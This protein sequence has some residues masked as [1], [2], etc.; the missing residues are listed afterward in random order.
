VYNQTISYLEK[1]K[2]LSNQQFGFR[3][4]HSTEL[5][6]TLFLDNIR[7]EM[8]SGKLCGAVFVDLCKAFDTISHS[9]IVCKL[10]EYGII[11]AEKEW[12]TNY[13]FGRTQCVVFD[14][15]TSHVNPVF[16]GVPQGSI[17]G[18]LLFLIHFN[19]VCLPVKNCKILMYADDTVLYYAHKDVKIIEQKLTEDMSRLSEWFENNELIVSLKKGKT[20]CMLFG[21][22]RNLSKNKEHE[23]NIM[24][25]NT[26][27]N[28]TTSYT[29]LGV[30][31]DQTLNLAD[32]FNKIYKRSHGRL[33]L[34]L[35]IRKS[36]TMR[37]AA[38]VYNAMILPITM[39]CSLVNP[40]STMTRQQQL[41][42]F[43]CKARRIIF[44]NEDPSKLT[45]KI[46]RIRDLQKKKLC[47]LTFRCIKNDVGEN[48][49]KYFEIIDGKY[50]TR[51]NKMSI[52]LPKVRLESAKN[53][54]YFLSG[55]IYNELPL[56]IRKAETLNDFNV[57]LQAFLNI[58]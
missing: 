29:Y 6:A 14:G 22:G 47:S 5:A 13:L 3:K 11:D 2:L 20:E 33:K 9:S 56:D 39:Y 15:C 58:S 38:T 49:D 19:G 17:L 1:N 50:G 54:F 12:F 28:Y 42:T 4:N 35:K 27:V 53:G 26:V 25:N 43:E 57:R 52:R 46:P 16:C 48:F 45:V 23:L 51:N 30:L 40:W 7:K 18:P 10:S 37:A 55:K 34:L 21:T 31:L 36:M 8:D 44:Q 24:Y 41:E 32:H